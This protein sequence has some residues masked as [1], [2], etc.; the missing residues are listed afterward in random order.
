MHT[1]CSLIERSASNKYIRWYLQ[2]VERSRNR[3]FNGYVEIQTV[4]LPD[5]KNQKK[6]FKLMIGFNGKVLIIK[7]EV[8]L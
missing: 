1:I 8:K 4:K 2:I 3:I 6:N 5:P 7:K